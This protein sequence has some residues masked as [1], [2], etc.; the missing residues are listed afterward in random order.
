M[1]YS[2]FIYVIGLIAQIFFSARTLF[3]WIKTEKSKSVVSPSSYWVLSIAGSW[4]FC[5][6]GWLRDDFSIILGQ[7]ISYYIYLWNLGNKGIWQ[8]FHLPLKSILL[9]TPV[10]AAAFMLKDAGAFVDNFFRNENVPFSLVLFGSAGQIIFT[11]RFIYQWAYSFRRHESMLPRGFW[12]ISLIGSGLIISYGVFRHDPILILGQSF[13]FVAYSRNLIIGWKE[14][15][16]NKDRKT[17]SE[18]RQ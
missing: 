13:G 16:K 5:L 6:Y 4:L 17:S 12:I 8:K 3:Q 18:P 9:L 15:T 10:V 7:F 2:V 14:S 1:E 11:L